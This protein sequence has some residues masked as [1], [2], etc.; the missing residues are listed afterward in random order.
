MEAAL[1]CDRRP[2]STTM[3][4]RPILQTAAD[5]LKHAQALRGER[6]PECDCTQ[7]ESNGSTEYRC[8]A[9]DHRWGRDGG[10]QC[11]LYGME[12]THRG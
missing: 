1:G 3:A 9:C 7:T 8:C 4:T 2:W 11:E 10:P 5:R 6:C 12:E